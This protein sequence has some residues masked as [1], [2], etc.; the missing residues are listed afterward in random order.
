MKN[1]LKSIVAVFIAPVLLV[2]AFQ[3]NQLGDLNKVKRGPALEAKE[4][5]LKQSVNLYLRSVSK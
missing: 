4:L 2:V 5:T 3:S 1:T